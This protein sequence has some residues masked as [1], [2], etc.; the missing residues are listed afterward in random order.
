MDARLMSRD[1]HYCP[2]CGA[3]LVSKP[4]GM[5]LRCE[6]CGWHLVTLR[7]W[8]KLSP[9]QQGYTLY[10]QESWPRSELAGKKNPHAEGSPAWTAFRQGEQRAVQDAQDS[11]E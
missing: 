3:G 9:F 4:P 7:E 10:A 1:R 6:H 11:E 2:S 8:R 5:R